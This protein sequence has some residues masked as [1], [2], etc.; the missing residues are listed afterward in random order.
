MAGHGRSIRFHTLDSATPVELATQVLP[1]LATHYS[2][3]TTLHDLTQLLL[4]S[5]SS[6]SR[7]HHQNV[8]APPHHHLDHDILVV[9]MS[10][11]VNDE[12]CGMALIELRP[13]DTTSATSTRGRLARLTNLCVHTNHRRCGR[14]YLLLQHVLRVIS[15]R[16]DTL[17]VVAPLHGEQQRAASRL[18]LSSGF[19]HS[20]KLDYVRYLLLP[21][22]GSSSRSRSGGGGGGDGGG[23]GDDVT[24]SSR[25]RARTTRGG[26]GTDFDG[27]ASNWSHP[28]GVV[29]L[30]YWVEGSAR[31]IAKV[32]VP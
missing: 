5:S 19:E 9:R 32:T 7:R 16:K 28:S 15:Q 14:G 1:F 2:T 22:S 20:K 17:V 26:G 24:L 10:F 21:L 11:A 4:S 27:R 30:E 23:D 29:E 6:S 13:P 25:S 12:T 8:P 18:L 31:K 3:T